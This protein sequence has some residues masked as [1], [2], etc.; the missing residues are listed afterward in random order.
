MREWVWDW[1]GYLGS[2]WVMGQV[3]FGSF[4]R[5]ARGRLGFGLWVIGL[6]GSRLLGY[7]LV[8]G[9]VDLFGQEAIWAFASL[10]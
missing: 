6:E 8:T 9:L 5:L 1:F 3:V 10:G 4:S 2:V 7:G